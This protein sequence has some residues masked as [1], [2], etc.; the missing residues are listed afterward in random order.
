VQTRRAEKT[1]QLLNPKVTDS[2][3]KA[4]REPWRN[5]VL[6][7]A[8]TNS[9]TH[10]TFLTAQFA[11]AFTG[12]LDA[13]VSTPCEVRIIDVAVERWAAPISVQLTPTEL[14]LILS[15]RENA[16]RA[17]EIHVSGC[18]PHLQ[19]QQSRKSLR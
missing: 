12:L 5:N 1:A 4:N 7:L 11:T 10:P 18:E 9:R 2:R 8:M 13:H 6:T 19:R 3:I 15:G 17:I 14:P 16:A